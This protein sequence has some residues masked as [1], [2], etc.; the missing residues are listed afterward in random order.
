M[1]TDFSGL[2]KQL[3]TPERIKELFRI[4]QKQAELGGGFYGLIPDPIESPEQIPVPDTPDKFL[5]LLSYLSQVRD[6]QLKIVAGTGFP[7]NFSGRNYVPKDVESGRRIKIILDLSAIRDVLKYIAKEN[8]TLDEA[9]K[10][11][12]GEIFTEMINHRNSLGYV[13]GPEFT[14]EFLANFLFFA[15]SKEPVYEIWKRLNPWNFFDFADIACNRAD[16]ERVLNELEE[17]KDNIEACISSRIE[18]YVP[19]NFEFQERFVFSVGWAI[20]GWATGKFGDI[21]IEHVKDNYDFLLDVIIHETFHRIQAMLYPG[22][23]GKEFRMLEKPLKDKGMDAL[24]KAMTYIFLEGSATYVQKGDFPVED[25]SDV[26]AG[27]DLF[28]ELYERVFQ[29][30]KYDELESLLNRGL[31][32]NGPFYALGHYMTYIIDKE[33]GNRTIASCLEKGSPEF[34]RLF[35]DTEEGRVFP[36]EIAGILRKIEIGS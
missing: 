15:A 14:M 4:Q 27:V 5:D 19:E 35:I 22:N 29:E 9:R 12:S 32:S 2:I 3:D 10:I 20:R 1:T 13:P 23:E 6:E 18:K 34:F 16:Y 26:Q 31:R 8:P 24:Y 28:K 25:M 36:E 11:A 21:N 33:Y 7:V 30:K 17:N